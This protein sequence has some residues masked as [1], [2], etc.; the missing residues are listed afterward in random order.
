MELGKY[1]EY[2]LKNLL[3][4][5]P[6]YLGQKITKSPY[7]KKWKKDKPTIE[8]KYCGGHIKEISE[9]CLYCK[10]GAKICPDCYKILNMKTS[11]KQ[12]KLINDEDFEYENNNHNCI[13][14]LIQISRDY[15]SDVTYT[16]WEIF[17]IILRYLFLSSFIL[18]SKFNDSFSKDI[19]LKNS[20]TR[21]LLYPVC[22]FY[23]IYNIHFL[24]KILL[25]PLFIPGAFIE[26]FNTALMYNYE[27]L[28]ETYLSEWP[29][30]GYMVSF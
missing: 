10:C 18:T 15:A 16:N 22:F 20:V 11:K 27:F 5:I 3:E 19:K 13:W 24:V 21:F 4:F 17:L 12:E 30:I 14:K 23:F 26:H 2:K 6:K 25:I 7:F 1:D 29:F 8:C 28:E 9:I